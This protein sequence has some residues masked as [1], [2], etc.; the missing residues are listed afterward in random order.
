MGNPYLRL[1]SLVDPDTASSEFATLRN[2]TAK[3]GITYN[4]SNTTASDSNSGSTSVTLSD[5]L[6]NTLNKIGVYFPA[7]L[8]I[9]ALNALVL[10]ILVIGGIVY[11]CRRRSKRSRTARIRTPN[12]RLTP[13][14]RNSYIAGSPPPDQHVYEPVSMAITEDTMLNPS[15]PIFRNFDG[16][17]GD[18]PQS[19]ATLPSQS[20]LYQ[21][22]GSEDALVPPSPSFHKGN[23]R[24]KSMG[25]PPSTQSNYVSLERQDEQFA[26]PVV[27]SMDNV[28]LR[29]GRSGV[30][31][32]DDGPVAPQTMPFMPPPSSRPA[33]V[34]TTDKPQSIAIPPPLVQ[35]PED[36][37]MPPS[38]GF[39]TGFS[40]NSP[41]RPRSSGLPPSQPPTYPPPP[42]PKSASP[43]FP[44]SSTLRPNAS[45]AADR[46]MS[47]GMLPSQ[48]QGPSPP[49]N[50]Q[51]SSLRPDT[52]S[53]MQSLPLEE[54]ITTFTP[55]APAFR[56]SP[57]G[58]GTGDRPMSM[59]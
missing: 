41:D 31:L 9:M 34:M 59:T 15:S 45:F 37:L 10:T 56:R 14:P 43:R 35:S 21:Q 32:V 36:V 30:S 16:R 29:S 1:L 18:R 53:D 8:G 57:S 33:S 48:M 44:G 6:A 23:D 52:G 11:L 17:M 3:A 46:P 20:K 27:Q 24:P 4:A 49:F 39:S 42:S 58:R 51:G 40:S 5:D 25:M 12:G 50:R 38:P 19:L 2:T 22:I 54:D 7:M 26:P 47:V 13:M 55:P 28:S